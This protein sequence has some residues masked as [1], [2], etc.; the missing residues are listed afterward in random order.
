MQD[1]GYHSQIPKDYILFSEKVKYKKRKTPETPQPSMLVSTEY[2]QYVADKKSS[3][4]KKKSNEWECLHCSVL[5]SDDKKN[6]RYMMWVECDRCKRQMHSSCMPEFH[7]DAVQ[8][9][10]DQSADEIDFI[11]EFCY[12]N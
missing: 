9:D 3:K 6:K 8:F 12:K 10:S 11:C 2:R 5:W 7:K 4:R 1:V